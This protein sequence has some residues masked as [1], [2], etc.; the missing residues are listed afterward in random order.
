MERARLAGVSMINVG[1]EKNTSQKTVLFAEK[2]V[3]GVYATVGV[4]PT[5]AGGARY[6]DTNELQNSEFSS[7][8]FIWDKSFYKNL[9][10]NKKVVAIG[11]CGL[12]YFRLEKE[13]KEKQREVF[14]EQIALANEVNKPLMLHIRPTQGTDDAYLDAYEILKNNSKV[15]GNLHFF[16]G[17]LSTA[18]KF[19]DMGFSTSFTGVITFTSAYDEIV[20]NAP[21]DLIMS[22]T[23]CPYVAPVPYRGKRNEPSFIPHIVKKIADIRN[24]PLKE[25]SEKVLENTKSFFLLQ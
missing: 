25:F 15:R 12:D 11:E 1:T 6:H 24:V 18:K 5:H 19:W 23:D 9:A 10:E 17:S 14:I 21:E 7:E 4:H 22:E 8:N 2:F 13:T 16:V 3:E 20:K